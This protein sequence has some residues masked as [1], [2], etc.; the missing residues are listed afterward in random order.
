MGGRRGAS[1]DSRDGGRQ[2]MMGSGLRATVL[3]GR[4]TLIKTEKC[5]PTVPQDEETEAEL[6]EGQGG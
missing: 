2:Q 6:E 3:I 5:L 1:A 4:G